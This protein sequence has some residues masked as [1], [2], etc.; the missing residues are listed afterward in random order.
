M[1]NIMRVGSLGDVMSLWRDVSY[2]MWLKSNQKPTPVIEEPLEDN[3][4]QIVDKNGKT[5]KIE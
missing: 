5:L 4:L 1:A 2:V 3:L